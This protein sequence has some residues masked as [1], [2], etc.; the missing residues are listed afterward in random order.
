MIVSSI[1][2]PVN[3]PNDD[4][5]IVDVVNSE[6]NADQDYQ[7]FLVPIPP[8]S[9]FETIEEYFRS[10]RQKLLTRFIDIGDALDLD[11]SKGNSTSTIEVINGHKIEINNTVYA[12]KSE[13]GDEV[14]KVRVVQIR[15]LDVEEANDSIT[16]T[17]YLGDVDEQTSQP[18]AEGT[19][20]NHDLEN[21][22][23]PTK[24]RSKI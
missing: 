8:Y 21:E 2:L 4:A 3:D 22:I 6:T 19:T 5:E 24:V 16:K 14:F 1:A 11:P 23:D 17:E 18:N 13:N 7:S 12:D 15:P 10:L 9:F 20:A